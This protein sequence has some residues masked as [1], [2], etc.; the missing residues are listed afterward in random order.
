[1]GVAMPRFLQK[2]NASKAIMIDWFEGR[3]SPFQKSSAHLKL[4]LDIHS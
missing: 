4:F 2:L 1:M 3:T